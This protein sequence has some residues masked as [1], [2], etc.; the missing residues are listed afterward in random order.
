MKSFKTTLLAAL[1]LGLPLAADT[2]VWDGYELRI[3]TDRPDPISYIPGEPVVFKLSIRPIL[4]EN[5][6]QKPE[7]GAH[8]DWL[9]RGDDGQMSTG[10][11]AFA[12]GE[13]LAVTSRLDQAG[14]LRLEATI[15]DAKGK[16]ARRSKPHPGAP[17]WD[18]IRDMTYTA[19]AGI[20][21]DQ[22]RQTKPEPAD[23]DAYWKAQRQALDAVPIKAEL[24]P[25]V[26]INPRKGFDF[27]AVKIAC[28]GKRPVT[29][30]LSIP[31]G[32]KPQ[33]LQAKVN[34]HGYGAG[35]HKPNF[36]GEPGVLFLDINAHG[37]ELLQPA[38]YY[39]TFQ[40]NLNAKGSYAF[41]KEE[42]SSPDT[43]YF[44]D[45]VLRAMRALDY[46]KTRPE[47]NRKDLIVQGS[48]QGGLQA[49]WA[50]G[51]D[52]D[53]TFANVGVTWNCDLGF[54]DN[55]KKLRGYWHIPWAP[56]LGYFDAVNHIKR[57]RA[58]VLVNRAGLADF[59]CPPS[60]LAVYYNAIPGDKTIVWVQGS[61]HG[62]I[63][64][65]PV[66]TVTR[67]RKLKGWPEVKAR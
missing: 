63:P 60:T 10:T 31:T 51:L 30:F 32:A 42:N 36:F 55:P 34:F 14:F 46:I 45:M 19:C 44:H 65:D 49:S 40:A 64:V 57:T 16:R 59:T 9:L 43:A 20:A 56:G 7:P 61:S 58:R 48:S 23:F 25:V 38:D 41:S 13:Y 21:I 62:Y 47:W 50:A 33:S 52:P 5:Q 2:C 4:P 17:K 15:V 18:P 66:A 27:F 54:L 29:G 53:V 24:T 35:E 11:V 8:L 26:P 1:L 67:E 12:T 22:L 39:K 37:M 6:L 3:R 28:A